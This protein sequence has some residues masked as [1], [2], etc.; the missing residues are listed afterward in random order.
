MRYILSIPA[1]VAAT[2][3]FFA[4]T[5]EAAAVNKPLAE[6]FIKCTDKL[7]STSCRVS[8]DGDENYTVTCLGPS[9][10]TL[11]H[12]DTGQLPSTAKSLTV[13]WEGNQPTMNFLDCDS[14][15][16]TYGGEEIRTC[17]RK[18]FVFPAPTTP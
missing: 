1:F 13:N 16:N 15:K 11:C 8:G 9:Y 7:I 10:Q 17:S 2:L 6:W 4:L 12:Y 3:G 18:Y 5:H 14:Y